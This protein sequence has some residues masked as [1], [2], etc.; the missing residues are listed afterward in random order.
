VL[1]D[2]PTS[3]EFRERI[4]IVAELGMNAEPVSVA[5]FVEVT[6]LFPVFTFR[7]IAPP[8]HSEAIAGEHLDFGDVVGHVCTG[9][10]IGYHIPDRRGGRAHGRLTV[11]R[12]FPSRISTFAPGM[13]LTI[14]AAETNWEIAM[15]ATVAA[16]AAT[17]RVPFAVR[18][19][20]KN[21]IKAML[22]RTQSTSSKTISLTIARDTN[23]Y[24]DT[25]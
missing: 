3:G 9:R 5:G 12:S 22:P 25:A 15:N 18:R 19:C 17:I 13:G 6:S 21:A 24:C 1:F 23:L 20:P 2:T 7:T 8:L 11:A 10:M 4:G 16:T 14:L